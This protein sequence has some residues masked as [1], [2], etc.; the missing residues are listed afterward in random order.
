MAVC[1]ALQT[2]TWILDWGK[3]GVADYVVKLRY[4]WSTLPVSSEKNPLMY[5]RD[6]EKNSFTRNSAW[7]S[8][9][10][11]KQSPAAVVTRRYRNTSKYL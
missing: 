8:S 11:T 4:W 5:I 3:L 6:Q 9:S 1:Q 7:K 2:S 10:I